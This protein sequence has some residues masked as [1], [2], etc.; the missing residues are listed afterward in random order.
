MTDP[1]RDPKERRAWIALIATGLVI[2]AIYVFVVSAG[3]L[4]QWSFYV[5]YLNDLA[6][7]FRQGHLHVATEPSAALLA[8]KNPFSGENAG[9]WYWDV[10]LHGGHY[11]L[12][13]G[14]V[15][16]L[17]LAGAK[18]L[19]RIDRPLG[20]PVM[21][22]ALASVQLAAAIW[23]VGRAAQ[24]VFDKP[25]LGLRVLSVAVIGL[26][27]PMPYNLARGAVYE[28]AIVGAHAFVMLGLACMFEAKARPSTHNRW[29]A[30]AGSAWALALGCRISVAP[31]VALLVVVG[32]TPWATGEG[33][34]RLRRALAALLAAGLP[35][36][37]GVGALLLY[38][39]LRFD[40][41]LEFGRRFQLTWISAPSASRFIL[42]NVYSYLMRAPLLSCRFPYVFA[43]ADL[44]ARAFPAGY[45]LPAGYFVYEQVAGT[46]QTLPWTWAAPIG[47]IAAV[48]DW[49]RGRRLTGRAWAVVMATTAGA[50]PLIPALTLASSTNRYLGD[51]V[52]GLALAGT[53][54][55]WTAHEMVR[56]VPSR[57]GPLLAAVAVL[58]ILSMTA[59]LALGFHGQYNH[60]PDNNR[61]LAQRLVRR[62]SVCGAVVPPPPN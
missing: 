34:A 54:G 3:H 62:L 51:V 35:V 11:Y 32:A 37:V 49:W 18:A 45:T 5:A 52:G 38:N 60:F 56:G 19:F 9:L 26:A 55:V 47:W 22:F 46:L 33:R 53:F 21:V 43:P 14:P 6:E 7:G 13:W 50:V 41:W 17:L 40:E 15:P 20:D 36:A 61:P 48:R 58:G 8:A 23:V 28:A 29:L 4:N 59:G 12:Y 31:A 24:T 44:G 57:R 16:A 39:R 2:E 10:S 27:N 1:P 42:P 25:P 30:L